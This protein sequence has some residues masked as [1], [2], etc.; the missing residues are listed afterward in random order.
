MI[1]IR[2]KDKELLSVE[3]YPFLFTFNKSHLIN[4]TTILERLSRKPH[5]LYAPHRTDFYMIYLFTDGTGKH[6]VDF[7]DLE[8]TPKHILFISQGQVHAFDPKETYDG[9]ALIFTESFFCR[10]ER[11]HHYFLNSLL[12]NSAQQPYFDT[13]DDFDY[14]KSLFLEI[15]DELKKPVDKF[16]GELLH[17]LLYR[18]FLISER[19]LEQQVK[20]QKTD[21][22]VLHLVTKF[23]QMVEQNYKLQKQVSFYA[24][25]L[26][27]SQR[28]LQTAIAKILGKS[29]KDWITERMILESKRILAY[30]QMSVKEISAMMNFADPTNFVKFFKKKTGTTP[31]GFRKQF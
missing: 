27:V 28:T 1:D 18:I 7:T 10:S 25:H 26:S 17:T 15:Y 23:K 12:F 19:C 14:L 29:P 13:G 8:V 5:N 2:K 22:K 30:D 3:T 6:M 21:M 24:N 9:M 31:T 11:D 4:T 16:Q 20:P